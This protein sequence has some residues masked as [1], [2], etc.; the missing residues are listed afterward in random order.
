VSEAT[1]D[2]F[3]GESYDIPPEPAS[4]V[5]SAGQPKRFKL[6]SISELLQMVFPLWLVFRVIRIGEIVVLY[7]E[8]ACGK[9]FVVLDL[10]LKI[11]A[12]LEWWRYKTRRGGVV[13]LAGEGAGGL[14]RRIQAW[15]TLFPEKLEVLKEPVRILPHSLAFMDNVEFAE[16]LRVLSSESQKPLAIVVD[17]LARYM[18]GG[19]ENSAKDMGIFIARCTAL[20][21]ATGAA[22]I[23]VHHKGKNQNA[24]RGSSALRGAADVM[25]EVKREEGQVVLRGEKSKDAEPLKP[26]Y[27]KFKS[28]CL[29]HDED[30]EVLTSLI[31]EPGVE[32]DEAE[33]EQAKKDPGRVI[34][35]TLAHFF[36]GPASGGLL[37]DASGIPRTSFYRALKA[38]IKAD[39]IEP[40][41]IKTVRKYRLTSKADEFT[42]PS[43]SSTSS[44]NSN[45]TAVPESSPV[46]SSSSTPPF[47]GGLGTGLELEPETAS[48]QQ[49]A[50]PDH[51]ATIRKALATLFAGEAS[52]S[53]LLTASGMK[54]KEFYAALASEI[55]AGRIVTGG[56]GRSSRY[57]LTQA[58][59]EFASLSSPESA[60]SEQPPGP[61][62]RDSES[63]PNSNSRTDDDSSPQQ[64]KKKKKRKRRASARKTTAS[65]KAP[66]RGSTES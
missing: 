3:T 29:G 60:N 8:S 33:E 10:I 39:R 18:I 43:S 31:L 48:P 41:E 17:T 36:K 15:E 65:A 5:D 19:D 59:P 66:S 14:G 47:R 12:G 37:M 22:I 7:G 52:R 4:G 56:K 34:R 64:K 27:L 42:S 9:T 63:G 35:E 13:Y 2:D 11:A 28:V 32:P 45:G 40:I 20:R 24:E 44:R 6:L 49:E 30:G 55:E 23:I 50:V 54:P 61:N 62:A 58:A 38:E 57:R 21:D 25:I 53:S 51:G 1:D 46:P 16:L 26:L